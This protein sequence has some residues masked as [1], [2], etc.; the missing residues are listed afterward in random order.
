MLVQERYRGGG[1]SGKMQLAVAG[2]TAVRRTAGG[3]KKR[4]MKG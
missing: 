3:V 1:A 4:V 2:G